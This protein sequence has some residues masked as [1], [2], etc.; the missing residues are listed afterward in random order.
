MSLYKTQQYILGGAERQG[1]QTQGMGW[2]REAPRPSSVDSTF[3]PEGSGPFACKPIPP[4]ARGS[5]SALRA[6][7][8]EFSG[9]RSKLYLC[10]QGCT[11][12]CETLI[13]LDSFKIAIYMC[14]SLL[15]NKGTNAL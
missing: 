1:L 4:A 14:F 13:P 10:H 8:P 9:N 3:F 5:A 15:F 6:E 12:M 11:R 2:Q 7:F